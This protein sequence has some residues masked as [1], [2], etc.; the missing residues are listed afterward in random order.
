[1][2]SESKYKRL[3]L[4]SVSVRGYGSGKVD[5]VYRYLEYDLSCSLGLVMGRHSTAMGRMCCKWACTAV[6]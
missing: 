1:M 5:R 2:I 6:E 3:Y 4:V